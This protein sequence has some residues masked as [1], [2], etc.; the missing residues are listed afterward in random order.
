MQI[1]Q[2]SPEDTHHTSRHVHVR[3]HTSHMPYTHSDITHTCITDMHTH[4]TQIH[5]FSY[6]HTHTC[7][8]RD[9]H[10]TSRHTPHSHK[11]TMHT[12]TQ[13]DTHPVRH[14]C[15]P[16]YT[17]TQAMHMHS[18]S[19]FPASDTHDFLTGLYIFLFVSVQ[20]SSLLSFPV[21]FSDCFPMMSILR[22]F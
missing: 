3:A 18:P 16:R 1:H 2:C 22:F 21:P 19:P 9:T 12:Y 20:F 5:T 10:H 15:T 14:K 13:T 6:I 7:T 4:H 17:N 8:H 11:C